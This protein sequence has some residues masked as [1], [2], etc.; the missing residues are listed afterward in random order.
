MVPMNDS[1][2]PTANTATWV[3]GIDPNSPVRT[4]GG[5][6]YRRPLSIVVVPGPLTSRSRR[7]R[8]CRAAVSPTIPTVVEAGIPGYETSAWY[9]LYGPAGMPKDIVEKIQQE[10][11]KISAQPDV[12]ERLLQLGAEPVANTPA[13]FAAFQ[14]AEYEKFVKIIKKAGIQ[15]D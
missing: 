14:K 5:N 13:E 15:P 8:R 3:V 9:G 6:R 7:H 1:P 12:R 2:P 11:A 4:S 10:I